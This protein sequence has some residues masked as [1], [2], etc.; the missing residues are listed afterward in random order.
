MTDEYTKR[1]DAMRR[2]AGN[3]DNN[4]SDLV[5]ILSAELKT[6]PA[7]TTMLCADMFAMAMEIN[8]LLKPREKRVMG[9]VVRKLYALGIIQRTG[10]LV[11]STKKRSHSGDAKEWSVV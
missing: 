1:D 4:Y 5:A 8:P 9:P 10:N 3:P 2:V 7:G 6:V 11:A